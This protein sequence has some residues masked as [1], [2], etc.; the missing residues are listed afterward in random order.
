MGLRVGSGVGAGFVGRVRGGFVIGGV[1]DVGGAVIGAAVGVDGGSVGGV[2]GGNGGSVK[3]AIEGA[4]TSMA[5]I[6]VGREVGN[7]ATFPLR[8]T[9]TIVCS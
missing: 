5:G 2:V 6:E 1:G 7:V 3:G 4:V 8:S 9:L